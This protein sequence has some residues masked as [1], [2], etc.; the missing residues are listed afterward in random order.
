MQVQ[1][2]IQKPENFLKNRK[3]TN[4]GGADF[5]NKSLHI[6]IY[7]ETLNTNLLGVRR[8]YREIEF[9]ILFFL[10]NRLSS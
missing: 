5:Y 1:K 10:V 3:Q 9:T 8:F 2:D 7:T 4:H 6:Y